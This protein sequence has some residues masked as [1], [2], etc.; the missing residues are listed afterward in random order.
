MVLLEGNIIDAGSGDVFPGTVEFGERI[1]GITE[2][3]NSYD[4]FIC[5]GYIDPH[6][7]IESTMMPPS[8]FSSAV[9][10]H[11]TSAV[12]ADPHEIANVLGMEGIELMVQ[13][14]RSAIADIYFTAPSCVPATRFETAGAVITPSDIRELLLRGEFVALGEMMNYPG[15]VGGNEECMEKI[16]VA[17]ALGKPIDGHCPGLS[18]EAL[19][20]Y[21]AAGITTEHECTTLREAKEK[22]DKG[23]RI[24]IREGS[25]AKNLKNL[26]GLK[27]AFALCSDDKHV[28]D[29]LKYGHMDHLLS[30][31]VAYGKDPIEAIKMVTHNP[32]LHYSLDSGRMQE[33]QL[34]NL[35]VLDDIDRFMPA[36]VYFHGE[37]VCVSGKPLKRT[38]PATNRRDVMRAMEMSVRDLPVG[39][40]SQG[41]IIGS[42]DGELITEHLVPEDVDGRDVQKLVVL[43]RYGVSA[44]SV[45]LIHGMRMEDCALAQTIAHDSHNI[46]ATGSED[47]LIAKAVNRLIT[48]GGGIVACSSDGTKEVPL[49]I[50]GL[51]STMAP[52]ETAKRL[53]ELNAF[54]SAHGMKM[55]NAITTLSFM[56]LLV[57]PHLKLSD[58]GLFD[59]DSFQFIENDY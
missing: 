5:P 6:I 43:S 50:A 56:A 21:V 47:G 57:I 18:G 27:E 53:A 44:P 14:S 32:S 13:D 33:G 38:I 36:K 23:M 11:G 1:V 48:M 35:L 37:P 28:D 22:A 30:M 20:R 41:H 7:H 54:L 29:I 15:V 39:E 19:E 3:S 17:K 31:A 16:N 49:E 55:N 59:V 52:N 45:A 12:V 40:T 10:P 58:K 9:A 34:A 51:M 42:I 25:S 26:I 2:N 46:I 24:F 8:I 4:R